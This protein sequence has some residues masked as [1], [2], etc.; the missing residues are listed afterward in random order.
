VLRFNL[1]ETVK[2]NK[3]IRSQITAA[4]EL[5]RG[6]PVI[7]DVIYLLCLTVSNKLFYLMLNCI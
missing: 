7:C 3:Y 4:V 2:H 5:Y 6:H 1:L